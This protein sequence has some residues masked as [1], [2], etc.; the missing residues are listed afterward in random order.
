MGPAQYSTHSNCQLVVTDVLALFRIT[1]SLPGDLSLW[2]GGIE[3]RE[4]LEQFFLVSR[5]Y[6]FYL[7]KGQASSYSKV[8]FLYIPCFVYLIYVPV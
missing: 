4:H 7:L 2:F 5:N 3:T 8:D 6:D 1:Q